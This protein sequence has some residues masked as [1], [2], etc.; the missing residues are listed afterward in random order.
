AVRRAEVVEDEAVTA[1]LDARVV[2]RHR[3]IG[4]HDVARSRRADRDDRRGESRRRLPRDGERERAL[5]A[6]I[7]LA[8]LDDELRDDRAR[9]RHGAIVRY[10]SRARRRLLANTP[11]PRR[12]GPK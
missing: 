12:H 9:L 3:R 6:A 5:L 7:R 11:A 8:A 2:A 4:D 10:S 1:Q